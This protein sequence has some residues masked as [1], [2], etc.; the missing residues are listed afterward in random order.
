MLWSVTLR[1]AWRYL[2]RNYRRSLIMLAAITVGVWA[3]IFMTAFMRGMVDEMIVSGIRNLPGHAQIF[4]HS[5]PDDPNI[6][7]TINEPQGELLKALGEPPVVQWAMRLEVPGVISSEREVRGVQLLGV[8]PAPESALSF[9]V[10]SITAGRWLEGADDKGLV[11]GAKLA[12]KLETRLGKRVVIM[13]QDVN[14]GIGERGIRVVGIYKAKLTTQEETVVYAGLHTVQEMLQAKGR[15]SQ[16]A[17]MG[18]DYRNPKPLLDVFDPIVSNFPD[19]TVR[20]W[21]EIDSYLGTMMSVMDGFTL[22]WMLVIFIALSFG[23][24]NTLVMAVFE[25]VREIGLMQALGMTPKLI[26]AQVIVEAFLLLCIGLL[27]GNISASLSVYALRDGIDFSKVAEGMEMFGAGAVVY[28]ALRS[29]D[30]LMAS[31]IVIFLGL[32]ASIL[33][34]WRASRYNPIIALNKT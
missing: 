1:L 29:D 3:M 16:I 34:A 15:V 32:A 25:R 10:D 11:I 18:T 31:G 26:I 28:P 2:W 9:D 7:N 5:Y 4:H 17:L 33:P 6:V 30:M 22:I 20:D 19:T 24:V 14:N 12:E 27:L 13:S 8:D 21:T 23:L